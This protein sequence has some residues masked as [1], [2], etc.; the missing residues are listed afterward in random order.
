[1][2][3]EREWTYVRK[4]GTRLDVNLAVTAVSGTD[5]A[6]QGFLCIATDITARKSLEREFR[7]NYEKLVAQTRSAEDANLAKSDFL[8][9]MSHEIRTPMNAIVGMADL[10]RES[11][12]DAGQIQYVDVIRNAGANLLVL[13]NDI[14]DL[15]KIEAGH[16]ELERI[17]FHP[18]K[19]IDEAVELISLQARAKGLSLTCHSS[20]DVATALVGDPNRLRQVLINVLG[21][22][23]KF[24]AAGAIE[25]SVRNHESGRQ[26]EIDFSISDT[27]IGIPADKLETIFADFTQADASMTRRYGGS[28]LGLG[29]SR[30][31]VEAMNG[32]L[33]VT[34]TVGKGS[35]FRFSALFDPAPAGVRTPPVG[36]E[37]FMGRRVLV[38]DG[39]ATDRLI[40]QETVSSW[41]MEGDV[42][43]EPD[44]AMAGFETVM[45]SERPYALVLLEDSWFGE[46]DGFEA[47]RRISQSAADLPIVMLTTDVRAG[48]ARRRQEAGL[49]GYAVKPV[50]RAELLRLVCDVMKPRETQ[51]R[52]TMQRAPAGG[53]G[54]H[55]PGGGGGRLGKSLHILLVEDSR[56][57]R[58]LVQA[59]LKGT[60]HRLDIAE[61]GQAAVDRFCVEA[62]ELILMDMQMPVMDG[63]TA[64][65]AIRSIERER[66]AAHVPIVALTANA[67]AQDVEI[68][69]QAGCDAHF[70]KPISRVKLL[71]IIEELPARRQTRIEI[72]PGL[73]ELVP[74]YLAGRKQ[75]VPEL[76]AVLAASDFERLAK[77]AHNIKGSGASYGFSDLTRIG[78]ALELAAE[79]ND[80]G[81]SGAQLAQLNDYLNHVLVVAP[82]VREGVEALDDRD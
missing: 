43:A 4:D 69:H 73:E 39:N 75:E 40:L 82:E 27:G 44:E 18:E 28:G 1:M 32:R 7:V 50:R 37:E 67:R 76:L 16:L 49:A 13:I 64:T 22:A 12:L 61:D 2:F 78:A 71:N 6:F 79:Q 38:I 55:Q 36:I 63:L 20:Q 74:E 35:T 58:L 72:P 80:A 51:L 66:G 31:L 21:N 14:L 70:S 9:A 56:D 3:E 29:I 54:E 81:G 30:R 41:G 57:N 11:Q 53:A 23:V 65:R 8:A 5:D 47:A 26:G 34:S 25:V 33:F 52:E 77:M 60:G 59:Y 17:E 15:S 42:F 19:V 46:R 48:D 24:T 68:S 62:F 45:A 10:L